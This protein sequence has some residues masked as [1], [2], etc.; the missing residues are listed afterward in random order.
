[1]PIIPALGRV[2]QEDHKSRP[3]RDTQQD[4]VG[5]KKKFFFT[6]RNIFLIYFPIKLRNNCRC[7]LKM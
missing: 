5:K 4:P 7:T 3:A 2:R 6:S 1:M